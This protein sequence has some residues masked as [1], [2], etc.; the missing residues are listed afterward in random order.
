VFTGLI[1]DLG[2]VEEVLPLAT[3]RRLRIATELPTTE[4]TVGASIAVSGAC[5]TVTERGERSFV[6]DVSA[7]SLRKTTLGDLRAGDRVNLERSLR[8]SDRIGGHLV[9]GHVDGI[10]RLVSLVEEGESAIFTFALPADLGR[11]AVEKGSIAVDGIS[12]TCFK[13]VNDG[14]DVAIIAHTRKVTTLGGKRVG[15]RVNIETDLLGKYVARWLEPRAAT[16][17]RTKPEK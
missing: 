17:A 10:G 5:M 4:L 6:V 1:E 14:F 7:E 8:L 15:D 16:D 12:L 2:R 9:T 3:G 13:C 11:S